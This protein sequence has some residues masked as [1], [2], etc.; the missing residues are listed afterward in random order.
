MKPE[1][2]IVGRK[3][4]HE[5]LPGYVFL[6]C[7]QRVMWEGKYTNV[8]SN[9]TNKHLVIIEDGEADFLGQTIKE[10]DECTSGWWDHFYS[11][12]DSK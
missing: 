9:F 4:K 6:G 3:Y 8:E 12:D 7:G 10:P 1:Q 5:L 2:I 11:L